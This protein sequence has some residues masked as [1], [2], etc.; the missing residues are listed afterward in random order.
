M[1][2]EEVETDD[3]MSFLVHQ[4]G[5]K[6]KSPIIQTL[7]RTHRE[8]LLY[9]A[10]A[11]TLTKLSKAKDVYTCN[12]ETLPLAIHPIE[13]LTLLHHKTRTKMFVVVFC[14]RKIMKTIIS[15]FLNGKEIS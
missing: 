8:R 15:L 9:T 1:E 11:V 2:N 4:T 3:E 13:I 6:P 12:L 7:V 14:N 5:K 10:C